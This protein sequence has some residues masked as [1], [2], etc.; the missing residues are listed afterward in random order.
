[1]GVGMGVGVGV[2]MGIGVYFIALYFRTSFLGEF[3]RNIP[4]WNNSSFSKLGV[5]DIFQSGIP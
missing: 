2:G 5:N 3:G 1:V 4:D